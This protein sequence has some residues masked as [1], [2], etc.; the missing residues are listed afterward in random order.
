MSHRLALLSRYPPIEGGIAAKTY[1]L[2]RGL[3]ERGHEVHV[4]THAESAGGEYRVRGNSEGQQDGQII[5]HRSDSEVPWHIP[6]DR[7]QTLNLLDL[8]VRTVERYGIEIIDSGYLVPYGIAGDLARRML[9]VR[10]VMRHGG[11]DVEKFLR[12]GILGRLLDAA[13][14]NA[15]TVVTE[16][17]HQHIFRELGG[18]L[19]LQPAYVPDGKAFSPVQ[20]GNTRGRLGFIGKIN[21]YRQHKRLREI[22]EIMSLLSGEFE[23]WVVGQGNGLRQFREDL[24]DGLSSRFHWHPFV[25]PRDM[26]ELL[27]QLDAIFVLESALPHP[28]VSNLVMEAMCTGVGVLTDRADLL[29]TYRDLFAAGDDHVLVVSCDQP[30]SAA[31]EIRSWVCSRMRLPAATQMFTFERYLSSNEELYTSLLD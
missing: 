16:S 14:S 21:Y 28:V 19:V 2:A 8:V 23:C 27:C 13:I 22:A 9:G 12:R 26:P 15:D 4:I 11:S 7:E 31:D 3:A 1:W 25:L 24:G 29:D 17:T 30:Q 6:E 10:H 5:V 20:D 18:K